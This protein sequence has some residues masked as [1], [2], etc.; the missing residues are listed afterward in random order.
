[1]Y[2]IRLITFAVIAVIA[3]AVATVEAQNGAL[4]VT[5]FPSGAKVTIDG[6]DTGKTTPMSV[7]LAS[8]PSPSSPEITISASRC[9]RYLPSALRARRE[10]KATKGIP[11]HRV[12]RDRRA[13]K[14]I[15]A[16]QA[17]QARKEI[18]VT[19]AMS[20]PKAFPAVVSKVC[21][22]SRMLQTTALPR[23]TPGPHLLE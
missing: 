11:V 17:L 22:H 8:A 12:H 4:K 3:A 15:P 10:T 7:S 14:V 13:I 20:G 16:P 9:C 2:Q 18:K 5:S 1:M 6:S 23:P 19:K 21:R